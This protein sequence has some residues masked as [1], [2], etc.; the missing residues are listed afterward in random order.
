VANT[1]SLELAQHHDPA[2]AFIFVQ[3]HQ[4]DSFV[5]AGLPVFVFGRCNVGK[6]GFIEADCAQFASPERL[7]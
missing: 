5:R 4:L 3:Y 2:S 7:G 1:A 6:H